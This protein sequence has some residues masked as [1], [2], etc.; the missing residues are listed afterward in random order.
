MNFLGLSRPGKHNFE[1]PWFFKDF[2][3]RKNPE[4]NNSTTE[5]DRT[6]R[7]E[8]KHCHLIIAFT[9]WDPMAVLLVKVKSM[10][11]QELDWL[12][13]DDV[14][15]WT[16]QGEVIHLHQVCVC[17]LEVEGKHQSEIMKTQEQIMDVQFMLKPEL[18]QTFSYSQICSL[19]VS[20]SVF[21]AVWQLTPMHPDPHSQAFQT[22]MGIFCFEMIQDFAL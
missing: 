8:G 12:G 11:H 20:S 6:T 2:H 16:Q 10:L 9:V 21:I 22:L 3:D 18:I 15:L 17:S 14:L 7:T 4:K 1:I 13:F 19:L 5:Y